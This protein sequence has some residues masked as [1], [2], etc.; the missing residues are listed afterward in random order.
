MTRRF[1]QVC[2][3][4]RPVVPASNRS[5]ANET[6]TIYP[7]LLKRSL[8]KTFTL[9]EPLLTSSAS[10]PLSRAIAENECVCGSVDVRSGQLLLYSLI[11]THARTIQHN[12]MTIR[13]ITIA[14][15][16]ATKRKHTSF[17]Q[18]KRNRIKYELEF[19]V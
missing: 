14:H 8:K 19:T 13:V 11:D 15:F 18:S 17:S 16:C 12:I 7:M 1:G 3:T 4:V 6:E 5:E 10:S 9:S 2:D